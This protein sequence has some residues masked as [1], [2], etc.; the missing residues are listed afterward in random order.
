MKPR[1]PASGASST[2]LL[3]GFFLPLLLRTTWTCGL[4]S[5]SIATT[6]PGG[7]ICE[8]ILPGGI[9]GYPVDSPTGTTLMPT[10]SA[11]SIASQRFIA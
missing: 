8:T 6:V 11:R 7:G 9:C 10:S 4:F 3:Y 1:S 2:S 5:G